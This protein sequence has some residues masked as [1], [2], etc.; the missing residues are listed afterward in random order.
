MKHTIIAKESTLAAFAIIFMGASTAMANIDTA[1]AILG[2]FQVIPLELP[3]INT[4][5]MASSEYYSDDTFEKV[6]EEKTAYLRE[7]RPLENILRS[8]WAALTDEL[9]SQTEETTETARLQKEISALDIQ[10]SEIRLD[11]LMSLNT[12]KTNTAD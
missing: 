1:D 10:L 12:I 11:H 7:T 5:A 9:A 4:S 3:E 8:K 2:R 6:L